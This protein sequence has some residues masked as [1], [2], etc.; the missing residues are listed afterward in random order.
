M[1]EN[2]WRKDMTISQNAKT[3]SF[4]DALAEFALPGVDM[5][6][7]NPKERALLKYLHASPG[8]QATHENM[9]KALYGLVGDDDQPGFITMTRLIRQLRRKIKGSGWGIRSREAKA[10]GHWI[11]R[12]WSLGKASPIRSKRVIISTPLVWH[13]RVVL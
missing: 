13:G 2:G 3:E 4:C 11:V 10:P 9:R 12:V 1:A 8:S 7:L 5:S 6:K